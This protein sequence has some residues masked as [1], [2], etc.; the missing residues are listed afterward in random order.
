MFYA[1]EMF[2]E[3]LEEELL[4]YLDTLMERLFLVLNTDASVHLRELA[5]GAIGSTGKLHFYLLQ[6][7]L[8][9]LE[10]FSNVDL[11]RLMPREFGSTTHRK[12]GPAGLHSFHLFPQN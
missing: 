8:P 10:S 9:T 12:R 11:F 1:L 5:I 2:C 7:S 6:D 4:P 3:N